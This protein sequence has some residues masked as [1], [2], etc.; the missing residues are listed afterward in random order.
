LHKTNERELKPVM[1]SITK[2]LAGVKPEIAMME[3]HD[4]N[5][6]RIEVTTKRN[7]ADFKTTINYEFVISAE[8]EELRRLWSD[9]NVFGTAP[10][11]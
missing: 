7:G 11:R 10:Y 5:N 4:V 9:L 3:D 2:L 1:D 6:N 8:F